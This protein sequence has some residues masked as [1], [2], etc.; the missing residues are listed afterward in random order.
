MY[1]YLLRSKDEALDAFKVFKMEIEKQYGK[2]IKIMIYDIGWDD[3]VKYIESGQ[4][5]V[6]LQ[7][8]F[9]SMWLLPYTL[10]MVLLARMVW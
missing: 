7:S 6:H 8:F 10:C 9:K 1:L 2:Q 4:R 5:V 3:Y